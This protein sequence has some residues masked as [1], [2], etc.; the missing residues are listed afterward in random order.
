MQWQRKKLAGTGVSLYF[1]AEDKVGE[2]RWPGG[3]GTLF[4]THPLEKQG[5]VR[6]SIRA[7]AGEGLEAFRQDHQQWT[8]S[9][10]TSATACGKPAEVQRATHEAEH[11]TCVITPEGNHPAYVPPRAAMAVV[12]AHRGRSVRVTWEAEA[13]EPTTLEAVRDRFFASVRCD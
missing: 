2:A 10:P 5:A 7:E 6:L 12:F 4:Q 11:I 3:G 8:F 1:F 13:E 9:P